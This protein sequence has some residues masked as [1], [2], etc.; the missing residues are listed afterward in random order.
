LLGFIKTSDPESDE[1]QHYRQSSDADR[2]DL[3]DGMGKVKVETFYA[4]SSHPHDATF[5]RAI[6]TLGASLEARYHKYGAATI[7]NSGT[8]FAAHLLRRLLQDKQTTI[9]QVNGKHDQSFTIVENF[10]EHL[11]VDVPAEEGHESV[12][13]ERHQSPLTIHF[14]NGEGR[15]LQR[16]TELRHR[17]S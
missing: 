3:R 10:N 7:P 17:S 4:A 14:P 16:E 1:R 5:E 9:P 15:R 2:E 11:C 8:V 12:S 6:S 13:R